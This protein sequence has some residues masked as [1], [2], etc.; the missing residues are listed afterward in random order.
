MRV[1]IT[2]KGLIN[3]QILCALQG[4]KE[5]LIHSAYSGTMRR[6]ETCLK[7]TDLM[8]Y[9]ESF[10]AMAVAK[11]PDFISIINTTDTD[12]DNAEVCFNEMAA[13]S[14]VVYHIQTDVY[15]L[16]YLYQKNFYLATESNTQSTGVILWGTMGWGATVDSY[17]HDPIPF[18][19]GITLPMYLTQFPQHNITGSDVVLSLGAADALQ[20]LITGWS[21]HIYQMVA[22]F[23]TYLPT[24]NSI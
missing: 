7:K 3:L 15:V 23:R 24:P 17:L 6:H 8:R 9:I 20:P 16:D 19:P 14:Q 11:Y 4:V 5:G 13:K 2:E 18:D 1:V 21:P 10:F 12:V 22:D